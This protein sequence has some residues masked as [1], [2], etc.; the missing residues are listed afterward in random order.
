MLTLPLH[1]LPVRSASGFL[2]R[3]VL[4]RSFPPQLLGP[5]D[6]REP[7]RILT[8]GDTIIGVGHGSASEFCGHYDQVIMDTLLIPDVRGKVVVLISC[9]TAQA[10]GP[11]LVEKGAASYI[12][13]KEDFVWVMDADLAS[14]P[15][16]DFEYAAPVMMPVI[17]CVNAVLDGRTTG[18]AFGILIEGLSENAEVEEDELVKSCIEFNISNAVLLGDENAR[19]RARPPMLLPFRLIPPP[20]ILLPVRA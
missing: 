7:F 5:A 17:N 11:K 19:V 8:I 20:P 3:H 16:A 14:T 6:R 12:G 10:L 13:F 18:E 4:P 2:I 9:E 15:W 1:D